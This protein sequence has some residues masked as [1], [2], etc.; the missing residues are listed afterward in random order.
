[1]CGITGFYQTN[2]ADR[3]EMTRELE[4]MSA[5]LVHRGPDSDGIWIDSE[6]GI[7]LAHRRLS[8]Q[9]LSPLGNQPMVSLSGRYVIV[10]NGEIYNF[11][12]LRGSLEKEGHSFR[13][14]SDTEVM[15]VAL[16]AW[17]LERALAGFTGMFAFAVW[18]RQ[19]KQ[20]ILARDRLGEKPLYYGW[21]G[22]SFLFGSEL[23]ALRRHHDWKNTVNRD[24]VGLLVRHN[25]IPAP[26]SVFTGIHKLLPG[27]YLILDIHTR[28]HRVE[29]FWSLSD[30]FRRGLEAPLDLPAGEIVSL[31]E[32]KLLGVIQRQMIAD[33]PV[34]AFLSGG[35]D[36]STVVALMQSLRTTPV[37][38]FTIGFN[39]DEYN[40]ARF[41]KSVAQHLGTDHTELYVSPKTVLEVI[42][43]INRIYD[44]P[45]ADSSQLPTFLIS[46]L[47]RKQVTVS[48]SGDG[49]DELFCGYPRYFQAHNHWNRLNRYPLSARQILAGGIKN[50]PQGLIDHFMYRPLKLFTNRNP[51]YAG[52]RLH[53]KAATWTGRTLQETYRRLI[54]YWDDSSVVTGSRE[55]AYILNSPL[56]GL[57]EG[58]TYKEMQYLD[59][60]CYLPDDILTKVDR[61]AM[62]NSLETRIPFL[63]HEFVELAARVPTWVN[64]L[65]SKG[66]WPLREILKRYVPSELVERPKQGFAVPVAQWL[67]HELRDWAGQFLSDGILEQTGMFDKKQVQKA[68]KDHQMG[69]V[70]N[71][72]LLWSIIVFQSWHADWFTTSGQSVPVT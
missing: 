47:A 33:V 60:A 67:R 69:Y 34:G 45:F 51:Y 22:N 31:L 68:W 10:F 38:T 71:S 64:L 61:A 6:T 7:Y 3:E 50:I 63:D 11:L 66:K 44:E 17:G 59:A 35:I 37:K 52:E 12:E 19:E 24:A 40:E 30:T 46:K 21:Q 16:E 32:D 9:D 72:F 4:A 18:D 54:S 23:K 39:E 58:D 49:G 57:C 14:G 36:S 65:H 13:G 15:L 1:M 27:S 53:R 2:P 29:C 26:W 25:Y 62:A 70:D 42:P 28:Q 48:L 8:I 43:E 5:T 56:K 20:L 41:A 55:L